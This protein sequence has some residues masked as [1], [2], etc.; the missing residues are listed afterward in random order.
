MRYHLVI[1]NLMSFWTC[2]LLA[3]FI[4]FKAVNVG[5]WNERNC[6]LRIWLIYINLG[7]CFYNKNLVKCSFLCVF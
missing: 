4:F 5:G 3:R 1:G 6:M 2:V 7:N